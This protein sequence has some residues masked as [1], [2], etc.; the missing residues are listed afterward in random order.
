MSPA[1]FAGIPEYEKQYRRLAWIL[2]VLLYLTLVPV[3][4]HRPEEGAILPSL[5]IPSREVLSFN[6][7]VGFSLLNLSN[8]LVRLF[9][10]PYE[11]VFDTGCQLYGYYSDRDGIADA[12]TMYGQWHHLGRFSVYSHQCRLC[13]GLGAGR[14]IHHFH[15]QRTCSHYPA[16]SDRRTGV[17]TL[18]SFFAMF[19]MEILPFTIS[20][21][22]VIWSVPIR[23]GR[24]CPHYYISLDLHWSSKALA[25]C[26]S[27]SAF[28]V[29]L[30]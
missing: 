19:F 7:I 6:I 20:S 10:T 22:S 8:G 23:W 16:H 28:T 25:W 24:Y 13:D 2:S 11:S 5:G 30:G 21:L 18:T 12:S 9:R 27:G 1:Y 29:R 17:M 15:H 3:I 14:R 4:F 26:P